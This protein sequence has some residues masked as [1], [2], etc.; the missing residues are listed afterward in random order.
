M[1]TERTGRLK[2]RTLVLTWKNY[3]NTRGSDRHFYAE[4][5]APVR[6]DGEKTN[7]GYEEGYGGTKLLWAQV[8]RNDEDGDGVSGWLGRGL[9]E[10][11]VE[12]DD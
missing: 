9:A 3:G 8:W 5:G 4:A 12:W 10:S 6:W 1:A 11:D 2:R 7:A